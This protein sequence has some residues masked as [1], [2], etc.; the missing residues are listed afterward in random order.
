MEGL[1]NVK[2]KDR[3]CGVVV[4]II[5]CIYSQLANVCTYIYLSICMN[6]NGYNVVIIHNAPDFRKGI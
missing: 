2:D 4:E 6:K 3:Q 5:Y 1:K